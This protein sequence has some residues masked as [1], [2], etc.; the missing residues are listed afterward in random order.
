M[1]CSA[2]LFTNKLKQLSLKVQTVNPQSLTPYPTLG[3]MYGSLT[4]NSGPQMTP[5]LCATT[6]TP[7]PT[8]CCRR[9][10]G[11]PWSS[12]SSRRTSTWRAETRASG[13]RRSTGWPGNSTLQVT[14]VTIVLFCS[15]IYFVFL[16]T[17]W[18]SFVEK[19]ALI[20]ETFWISLNCHKSE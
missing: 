8:C 12:V 7:G 14:L 18:I 15:L 10:S 3:F 5:R 16:D 4:Q 1:R 9:A 6:P 19:T 11:R 2:I 13:D 20:V 17:Y